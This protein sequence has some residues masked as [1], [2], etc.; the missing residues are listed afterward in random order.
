MSKIAAGD[1]FPRHLLKKFTAPNC[2]ENPSLG[3]FSH[4]PGTFRTQCTSPRV[5]ITGWW[6]RKGE[7]MSTAASVGWGS[8]C[9]WR[10]IDSKAAAK[11]PTLLCVFFKPLPL[12]SA[13]SASHRANPARH[14][15]LLQPPYHVAHLL[16]RPLLQF[17]RTKTVLVG[18]SWRPEVFFARSALIEDD[19]L[20]LSLFYSV[21]SR[22][23]QALRIRSVSPKTEIGF[24]V[25]DVRRLN[26]QLAAGGEKFW[27]PR[28][29]LQLIAN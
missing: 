15:C 14:P 22:S 21:P 17:Y 2:L 27:S 26:E 7:R 9:S 25:T 11:R 5:T 10:W 29:I 12:V 24:S 6:E 16:P 1:D 8:S 19:S 13:P 23:L 4:D 18:K 28:E 20:P 3:G